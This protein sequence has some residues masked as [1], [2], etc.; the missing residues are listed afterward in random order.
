MVKISESEEKERISERRQEIRVVERTRRVY[1]HA[2]SPSQRV[3]RFEVKGRSEKE[4]KWDFSL[5]STTTT[6]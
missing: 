2:V 6:R 1:I 4:G 5:L 3:S